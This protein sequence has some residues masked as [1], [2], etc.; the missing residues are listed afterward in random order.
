MNTRVS[1]WTL[2]AIVVGALVGVASLLPSCGEAQQSLGLTDSA[3][4]VEAKP[5]LEP[6]QSLPGETSSKVEGNAPVEHPVVATAAAAAAPE[7][8]GHALGA[9][10]Q[11]AQSG[12][13]LFIFFSK[14]EDANTTA[15]RSVFDTAMGKAR[16]RADSVAVA[17]NDSTE[18]AVIA[19]YGVAAAPMPLVLVVAPNGAL[20]GGFPNKFDEQMLFGAFAS[21]G[22][23]RC[24]KAL[25][26]RKLVLL[27]AQNS[28]TAANEAAT[29]GVQAFKADARYAQ[30][31]EIILIDPADG[32]ESRLMAQLKIEPRTTDA[33]TA[34]LAP[35][36]TLVGMFKGAV[37]KDALVSALTAPKPSSCCPPG[38]SAGVCK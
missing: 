30:V 6:L 2:A 38:T 34:L 7:G 26:E 12:K 20:A 19:K 27:C 5:S 35:P 11:A 10:A 22:M 8:Q 4:T 9:L 28:A 17:L 18:K 23:E 33:I 32:A 13:Y 36:G 16:D 14:T 25:Q 37:T 3:A 1:F 31:T 24:L 29:Q 21:P 15:M